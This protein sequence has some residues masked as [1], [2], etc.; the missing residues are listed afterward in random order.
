[1]NLELPPDIIFSKISNIVKNNESSD[2]DLI[3]RISSSV[4]R[5]T[6]LL[7]NLLS[8]DINGLEHNDH[9]GLTNPLKWEIGHVLFFG[10]K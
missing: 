9:L 1:M 5:T 4:K 10:N 2:I 3:Y 8:S 6:I 7:N